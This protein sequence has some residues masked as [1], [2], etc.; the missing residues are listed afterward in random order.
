MA[1]RDVAIWVDTPLIIKKKMFCVTNTTKNK[2]YAGVR[3]C[4]DAGD[5][6]VVVVRPSGGYFEVENRRG[7]AY[8]YR[9]SLRHVK[10]AQKFKGFAE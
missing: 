8:A 9:N 5:I 6:P 10:K 2:S 1:H 7:R 4:E 3:F